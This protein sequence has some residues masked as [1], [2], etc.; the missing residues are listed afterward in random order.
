MGTQRGLNAIQVG[1]KEFLLAATAGDAIHLTREAGPEELG[2]PAVPDHYLSDLEHTY[3]KSALMEPRW[4]E[5]T[6]CGR[7]WILMVSGEEADAGAAFAPSCRR[8]LALMDKLFPEP[9]PDDRL[10]LVVQIIA[11]TVVEH[12]YAEMWNV[13]GDQQAVLR[14]KARAAL[15]QR[16]GYGIQTLVHGTMVVFVCEPI[17]EQHRAER[18]HEAA[19]VMNSVLTGE[20]APSLPTP[21]RL[22][23]DTWAAG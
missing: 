6:L 22:S 2:Q 20:P 13:P 19:E 1:D 5:A 17:S 4:A 9:K 3:A 7:P 11:D 16:T 12:G 14:K 15:R 23:W 21:W 18:A 10:E 8:C